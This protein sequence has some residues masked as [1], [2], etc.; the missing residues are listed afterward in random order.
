MDVNKKKANQKF[1]IKSDSSTDKLSRKGSHVESFK[2][3][4][5]VNKLM[6]IKKDN[7]ENNEISPIKK[8]KD[9]E[10]SKKEYNDY[11]ILEASSNNDIS[12]FQ[13]ESLNYSFGKNNLEERNNVVSKK[14][15][16]DIK[17]S[18][19][20]KE[21][22]SNSVNTFKSPKKNGKYSNLGKG[23]ISTKSKEKTLKTA[24]TVHEIINEDNNMKFAHL[25]RHESEENNVT[26]KEFMPRSQKRDFNVDQ[27]FDSPMVK[28][29]LFDSNL[30][31][32]K[33][34]PNTYRKVSFNHL[35]PKNKN[36][37]QSPKTN[38][39]Q[40]NVSKSFKT[41]TQSEILALE[42]QL[43]ENRKKIENLKLSLYHNIEEKKKCV[44][45]IIESGN[46]DT[47]DRSV[48]WYII[49][50][51]SKCKRIWD[52]FVTFFLLYS[53]ILI[54]IDIAWNIEC[55]TSDNGDFFKL[56]YTIC[57]IIFCFDLGLMFITAIIDDKNKYIYDL[58]AIFNSKISFNFLFDILSA[59]PFDKLI[60]SNNSHCFKQGLPLAK[61]FLLFNMVRILKLGKYFKIIEDLLEKY[62]NIVRLVKLF[63]IL[64]Y[65]AHFIGN[66]FAGASYSIS[67]V[68]YSSCY[69]TLTD[70]DDLV[71]CQKKLMS[72]KFFSVYG[73]SLYLGLYY[74]C[75]NEFP[76][77]EIWERIVA[78]IVI[79]CS[80]ALNASIFGN[81][82]LMISKMSVG[83]DPFVQ[84]KIDVMK[85]YMNFKKFDDKFMKIIEDYH[86][87]IWSKQ[88][89][90]MYPEGFFDNMSSALQKLILLDQWKGTFFEISNILPKVSVKFFA[91]ILPVL[92]PKIYMTGDTIITEGESTTTVYFMGKTG[93]CSVKIG[94]EW[95]RNMG[96]GEFFGEVAILLRSRR[97]TAT[98]TSLVDSD[99]LCIEGEQFE[100]L[101]RDHP[102]DYEKIKEK[103]KIRI[104]SNIKLYPSNL[105]AKL[106]P[107]NDL[108]D[109][110]IRKIIYLD[111]EEEDEK[112]AENEKSNLINMERIYPKFEELNEYITKSQHHLSRLIEH[113]SS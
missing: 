17:V 89:N 43:N 8:R 70:M 73:Y 21:N 77:T 94:G 31:V 30:N 54:P 108:K 23:S 90:M 86:V 46:Y 96:A 34:S 18:E 53:L 25:E 58:I 52:F 101:I 66:V 105:Y 22:K 39:Q 83:L 35:N 48:P 68:I 28:L 55:F 27:S 64:T 37:I 93:V 63:L 10:T 71:L 4:T 107:K 41:K 110:L 5:S 60:S 79:I 99:F 88:R 81:V 16:K 82:A 80:I 13:D 32:N 98:V 78:I 20:L 84:E 69:E 2:L 109:Y 56:T 104:L 47:K 33:V 14:E 91:D 11:Q 67:N 15:T 36:I 112:L 113:K 106:V 49:L 76:V 24:K 38:A 50:P 97:R 61:V 29:E 92:K 51:N 62:I 45:Y 7:Y 40:T 1:T 19:E 65:L 75:I 74:L 102:D 26:R 59:F 57:T 95:I 72:D 87:N 42:Q 100:K 103:G 6:E 12:K 85:E 3:K 44:K 111:D 9:K